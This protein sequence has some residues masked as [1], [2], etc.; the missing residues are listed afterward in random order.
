MVKRILVFFFVFLLAPALVLA[1][2]YVI[3]D[4]DALQISVWGVSELSVGA[5]VRP[6]GKIT[7]PGVGDITASGYTPKALSAKVAENLKEVVKK[8]IVT[9]TVTGI[10][11]NKI[12]IIGGGVSSGVQQLTGRTTLLKFMSRYGNFKGADLEHAYL[13]RN[14]KKLDVDFYGLLI[15]GGLAKDIALEPEDIIYVPDNESNKIYI[16]GEV[17]NPKYTYYRE[18][19]RIL[20]A[21]LEAGGF[22]KFANENK[23]VIMR[24]GPNGQMKDITV[25]V[26]DLMKG[27]NLS[28][29]I[30]LMPG[31]FVIVKESIF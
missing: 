25:R 31:D 26:K 30:L 14:N 19:F 24:K 29:N 1:E 9:V 21:I 8:P 11:N 2:D 13:V 23:V 4:G 10:T 27:G 16:M 18:N 20:D 3:G 22:S 6:D 12:Y 28:E 7:I 5:V 17:T 15:K